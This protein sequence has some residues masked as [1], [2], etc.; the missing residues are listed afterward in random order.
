MPNESFSST[1]WPWLDHTRKSLI[2]QGTT[3]PWPVCKP[4]KAWWSTKP[5]EALWEPEW[6][7]PKAMTRTLQNTLTEPDRRLQR[8]YQKRWSARSEQRNGQQKVRI[9]SGWGT[10]IANLRYH[11]PF[12]KLPDASEFIRKALKKDR[13]AGDSRPHAPGSIHM[14]PDLVWG[15]LGG[16]FAEYRKGAIPPCLSQR[17]K[18]RTPSRWSALTS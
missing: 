16:I 6:S 18:R 12:W 3:M 4:A 17:T 2:L 9:I 15:Y 11:R 10:L 13:V 14:Q 5:Y 8:M 1:I 7:K